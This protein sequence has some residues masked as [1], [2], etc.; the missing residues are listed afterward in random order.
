MSAVIA[1][2]ETKLITGE[3]LFAMGDI[4]PARGGNIRRMR[5]FVLE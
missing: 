3:E 1:P 5:R 2:S 4:G